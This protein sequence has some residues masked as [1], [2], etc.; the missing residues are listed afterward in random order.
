MKCFAVTGAASGICN[1]I[2]ARLH[3]KGHR[4]VR[5]DVRGD[6]E[7]LA[8]LSTVSGR[9]QMVEQIKVL[10]PDGLDGVLAGAGVANPAQQT[11][12]ISVNYFG[13]IATLEGLRPLLKSP[14]GRA[15][16]VCSTTSFFP[17]NEELLQLCRD[18]DEQAACA[19]A[20]KMFADSEGDGGESAAKGETLGYGASKRALALWLREAAVKPEW[21]GAGILLNAIG[22]GIIRTGMTEFMLDNPEMLQMLRKSN[23][24]AVESYGNPSDIAEV[25][26]FLLN[27]ESPFLVGQILYVDGGCSVLLRPDS[28]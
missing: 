22:P 25:A 1:A 2:A 10:C 15:V 18:G 11:A 16:A 12:M 21:A 5:V 13:A 6:V 8:D 20:E 23:P 26:D 28:L 14:G 27:I 7:V 4:V 17:A 19:L 3:D 24:I 9:D